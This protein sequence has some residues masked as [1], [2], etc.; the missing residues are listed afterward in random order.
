MNHLKSAFNILA[1][2]LLFSFTA[3]SQTTNWQVDKVHSS[4]GFP[5]PSGKPKVVQYK[6]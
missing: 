1:G 2:I 5:D 4:I 6:R 3:N